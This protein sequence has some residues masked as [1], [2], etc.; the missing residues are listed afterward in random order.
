MEMRQYTLES[1]RNLTNDVYE[2][3]FTV[4]TSVPVIPGQYI[5]FSLD[6]GVK[7]AYSIGYHDA[8]RFTFIIKQLEGGVGSTRICNLSVGETITGTP[9]IGHFTLRPTPT[10]KLFIATGT[11]FAPVYFQLRAALDAGITAPLHFIFGVRTLADVFYTDELSRLSRDHP[12]VTYDIYLSREVAAGYREGYVTTLVR[13]DDIG[14]R[15]SEFYMCGSPAMVKEVR[16]LLAE[17]SVTPDRR[18]FEQY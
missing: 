14:T 13:E 4:D 9:P 1:R 11:G 17:R 2:L 15:F 16:A 5:L 8:G 10:A 3:T 6:T 7:R 12:N 18:F